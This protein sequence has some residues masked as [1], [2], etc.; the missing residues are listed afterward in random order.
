M[1]PDSTKSSVQSKDDANWEAK[2]LK[3]SAPNVFARKRLFS[4]FFSN[5]LLPLKN[6]PLFYHKLH[7][8]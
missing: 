7:S 2:D 4:L 8:P 5:S 1:Q 3:P 6:F